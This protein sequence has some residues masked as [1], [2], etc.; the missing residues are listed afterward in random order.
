MNHHKAR[1]MRG[2][3][4]KPNG[5]WHY[6]NHNDGIGT[7][8]EGY[9]AQGCPGHDTEHGAYEH[10]TQYLRDTAT[11][12]A[13]DQPSRQERCAVCGEWTQKVATLIAGH[14]EIVQPL[15]EQHCTRETLLPQMVAGESWGSY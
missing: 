2:T 13:G 8:A 6:T 5:L 15:C 4:G 9:C 3:D 10:Q 1:E 7:Y 11:F 14:V 12:Y